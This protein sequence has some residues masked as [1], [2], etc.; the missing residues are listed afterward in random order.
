MGKDY[1]VK[2][3]AMDEVKKPAYKEI[4]QEKGNCQI[5]LRAFLDVKNA[6]DFLTYPEEHRCMFLSHLCEINLSTAET[7]LRLK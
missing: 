5:I 6:A 2:V 4:M 7:L 3:A 1:Q